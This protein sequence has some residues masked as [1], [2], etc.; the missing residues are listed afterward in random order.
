MPK[1]AML[2]DASRCTGCGACRIACQMQWQLPPSM[3]YNSLEFRESGTYP[4]VKQEIVPFQCMHCDN[5]PCITVCPTKANF[6]R[7]DGIV[8]IDQSKCIGCKSCMIACPYHVRQLNDSGV[9]EKCRF[10]A[11]YVVDGQQPP[12][13]STCMNQVRI[14]GD[15]EDASS[16]ISEHM[17][18]KQTY[19]LLPGKKTEPRVYYVK[20]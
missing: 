4:N 6:K 1:Y 19:R 18:Q 14:F 17:K 20:K 12:C 16:Q 13:V 3:Y 9:P 10:C 8:L 15:L 2:I 5:A 11:E 7:A